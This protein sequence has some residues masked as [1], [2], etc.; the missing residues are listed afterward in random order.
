MELITMTILWTLDISIRKKHYVLNYYVRKSNP[1]RVYKFSSLRTTLTEED[2][3]S[4]S[5][6]FRKPTNAEEERKLI[7][8][9]TPT[10]TIPLKKYTLKKFFWNGRMVGE[11]KSSTRALS[12]HNLRVLSAMLGHCYSQYY[13]SVAELLAD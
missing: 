2:I 7:E 8:N 12:I 5:R 1:T 13:R 4:C 6:D 3:V 10:S 9:G 11:Q